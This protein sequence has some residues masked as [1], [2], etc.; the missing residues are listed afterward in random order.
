MQSIGEQQ[1]T[2]TF[3]N[4]FG[5]SDEMRS[6]DPQSWEDWRRGFGWRLLQMTGTET[7]DRGCPEGLLANCEIKK[8]MKYFPSA[9]LIEAER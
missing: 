6:V 5:S 4:S 8:Y 7:E 9:G 1:C 3:Q 2:C